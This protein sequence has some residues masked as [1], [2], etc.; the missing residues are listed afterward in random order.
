MTS[1][2]PPRLIAAARV[3][4][5]KLLAIAGAAAFLWVAIAMPMQAFRGLFVAK[6]NANLGNTASQVIIAHSDN[7]HVVTMANDFQG[8]VKD[9]ARIVPV[10]V[11]LRRDQVRIGDG[12]LLEKM[13]AFTAPRL[14]QYFDRPCQQEYEWYRIVG[15]LAIPIAAFF[16]VAWLWPTSNK[17][18]LAVVLLLLTLLAVSALPSFLHQ[19]TTNTEPNRSPAA[20]IPTVTVEDQF[21]VGDYDVVILSAEQS[22]QLI[23][24]LQQNEYQ[25]VPEAASLLQSYVDAGM[26]FLV[27]R[28]NLAEFQPSRG[29]AL[30]PIVLDYETDQFMLPIRLGTLNATG[31]QDL[32]IHILSPGAYAETTNYQTVPVPTDTES[33]SLWPSGSEIPAFVQ[34]GFGAFYNSVFQRS[35]E[36]HDQAVFLEY[37]TRTFGENIKCDPCTVEA[38]SIPTLDD[39][40]A[41]GAWWSNESPETLITRLHVR[42]NQN[43]FPEDLEFQEI[44]PEQL[45]EKPEI[46]GRSFPQW[47]G[48]D[49]QARYVMR[50]PI[51]SAVCM[52]R[53]W[54]RQRMARSAENLATLTG[55]DIGEIRQQIATDRRLN[56]LDAEGQTKLQQ[57][58]S[59]DDVAQVKLLIEQGANV[60]IV[61]NQWW[62]MT[63][64][65][66]A[67]ANDQP[68]IVQLLIANGAHTNVS[69]RGQPLLL[70]AIG[71]SDLTTVKQ[72]LEAGVTPSTLN[73]VWDTAQ[74][75]EN[76]DLVELLKPYV[77]G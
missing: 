50:R 62:E 8:D 27:V 18:A 32:I 29:Q 25:V 35:Y 14:T 72:L 41:M 40:K 5:L 70:W 60:N 75:L 36:R 37:A 58:I 3:R 15:F 77:G 67:I 71:Y 38:E 17:L 57:A 51:G 7:R 68:E 64:L 34:T 28:V 63:P 55:W 65:V 48:V 73:L 53:W 11:V 43:T 54:Y 76:E 1:S 74:E 26:K 33:G 69:W 39:L 61:G 56:A 42:Y 21:T 16:L 23:T 44:T 19:A 66:S 4:W 59:N 52:S 10:P 9:F 45:M 47:A 22:N 2:Q 13:S 30:K 12:A 20:S 31:D 46:A 24:W 6:T 49:F